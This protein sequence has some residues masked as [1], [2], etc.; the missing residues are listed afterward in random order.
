MGRGPGRLRLAGSRIPFK[1]HAAVAWELAAA[2]RAES[3]Y[4]G[5]SLSHR[6]AV[7]ESGDLN[8]KAW[9]GP[10]GPRLT[11]NQTPHL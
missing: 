7:S 9:R 2:L 3:E 5:P 8:L 11:V 4:A 1:Q 6:D 10:I